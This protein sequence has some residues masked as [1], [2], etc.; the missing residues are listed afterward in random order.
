MA[1]FKSIPTR[2]KGLNFRSRLEATWAA[3]FDLL[4]WDWDYEPCEF[5]GWFPDFALLG[6]YRSGHLR[7]IFV[8]VKPVINFPSDVAQKII[9]SQPS[10]ESIILGMHPLWITGYGIPAIGWLNQD[11]SPHIQDDGCWDYALFCQKRSEESDG[12]NFEERYGFAHASQD[13]TCRITGCYD[14]DNGSTTDTEY[15]KMLWNF[16]KNET[17]WQKKK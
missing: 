9:D 4:K 14:G 8:E 7:H 5:N 16:A 1:Q 13:F 10:G 2:Y 3:F 17:Q 12:N 15:L 11:I 6:C